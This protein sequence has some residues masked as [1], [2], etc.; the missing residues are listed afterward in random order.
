MT[1]RRRL[2]APVV[3]RHLVGEFLRIFALALAAFVA[4]YV[5]VD[6]FDRFDGFLRHE[7]PPGAMIRYFVFKLPLVVTQVAPF[8]VDLRDDLAGQVQNYR[9]TVNYYNSSRS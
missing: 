3:A 5:I 8:A 9:V 1:L 4:I 7:A 2:V 6:F